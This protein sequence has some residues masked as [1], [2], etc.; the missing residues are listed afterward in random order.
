MRARARR[1]DRPNRCEVHQSLF[2][3]FSLT[4]DEMCEVR[5]AAWMNNCGKVTTPEYVVGKSTKLET[6]YDRI[7]LVTARAEILKRD[8][9]IAYLHGVN[10]GRPMNPRFGLNA[11]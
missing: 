3:D 8:S 5:I 7:D 4:E 10:G 9:E 11:M 1:N 2:K 6:I